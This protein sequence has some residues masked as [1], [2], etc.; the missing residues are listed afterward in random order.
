[1]PID[2]LA[3]WQQDITHPHQIDELAKMERDSDSKNKLV[4]A[5]RLVARGNSRSKTARLREIFDEVEAA[6]A[7]GVSHKQIVATLESQGLVFDQGTFE[8]TRYRIAKERRA[9]NQQPAQKTTERV[10]QIPARPL[11]GANHGNGDMPK[12]Q[13]QTTPATSGENPLRAL[14]GKPKEGDYN[15]IP[16][17]KFEVDN[18]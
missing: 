18:S 16:T 7:A 2:D 13:K 5:L 9:E 14:S 10:N 12:E 11:T 4:E 1:M 3:K 8:I 6:R 15:P 17:A